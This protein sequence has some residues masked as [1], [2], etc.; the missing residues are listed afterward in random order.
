M[1]KYTK[2]CPKNIN[3]ILRQGGPGTPQYIHKMGYTQFQMI[4]AKSRQIMLKAKKSQTYQ[5][6]N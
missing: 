5:F 3:K 4:Q 2:H 6:L 1:N